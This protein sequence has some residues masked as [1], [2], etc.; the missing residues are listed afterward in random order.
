MEFI[1]IGIT[2]LCLIVF[3]A[4]EDVQANGIAYTLSVCGIGLGAGGVLGVVL[5]AL[6]Q[7]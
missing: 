4:I 2:M 7:G 1:F 3:L 6:L 5:K